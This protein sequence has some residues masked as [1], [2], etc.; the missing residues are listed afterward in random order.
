MAETRDRKADPVGR[1]ESAAVRPAD[2][3]VRE[4]QVT[5]EVVPARTTDVALQEHRFGGFKVGSAFFGWLSAMGIAAI[6]V[7]LI[8]AA[9]AALAYSDTNPRQTGLDN[10][11][12][13]TIGAG[14]ALV[15]VLCIAYFAGGY[16]A[17]RMARFSGAA[18]GFGVWLIGL[19]VAAALAAAGAAFGSQYNVLGRL[20]LPRI[21]IDEG[22]LTTGGAITLAAVA[23]GTLIAAVLGGKAGEAYHRR[24]DRAGAV[25]WHNDGVVVR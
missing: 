4:A 11:R 18:N 7:G 3:T 17:G 22:S 8:A 15:A 13:I 2:S 16:V 21:P 19:V 14:I 1:S 23:V 25:G 24:I 9:G 6:L 12:P 10:A 5:D 20:D